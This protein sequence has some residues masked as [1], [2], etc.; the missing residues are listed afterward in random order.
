MAD[1][2]PAPHDSGK[3]VGR[4]ATASGIGPPAPIPAS[5]DMGGFSPSWGSSPTP[6]A[7]APRGS[8]GDHLENSQPSSVVAPV[9]PRMGEDVGKTIRPVK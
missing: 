6:D 2:A 8:T 7:P 1:T 4:V 5:P 3:G 9:G